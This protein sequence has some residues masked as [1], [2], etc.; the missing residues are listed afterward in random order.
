MPY[1]ASTAM[2]IDSTVEPTA[3]TTLLRRYSMYG[4]SRNTVA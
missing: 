1:A 4:V 3:T 2:I